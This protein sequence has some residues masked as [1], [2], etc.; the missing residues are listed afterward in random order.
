MFH[1]VTLYE[2]TVIKIKR[3][4]VCCFFHHVTLWSFIIKVP[5]KLIRGKNNR[6]T[7]CLVPK[8]PTLSVRDLPF[9]YSF[10]GHYSKKSGSKKS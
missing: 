5:G 10:K 2:P 7:L 3:N 4:V 1:A 9:L 6:L 8:T